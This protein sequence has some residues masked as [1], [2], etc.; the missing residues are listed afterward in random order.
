ML[1]SSLSIIVITA[2]RP[3]VLR[4]CL[5]ALAGECTADDE[6]IVVSAS[7]G[8]PEQAF[9]TA[10][11]RVRVLTS[12]VRNMPHQRN[13]GLADA[14][15]EWVAFVDDDAVVQPGWRAAILHGFG[16]S[17]SLSSVPPCLCGES[18][19][20][21]GPGMRFLPPAGAA[22]AHGGTEERESVGS[23]V[24]REI[25]KGYEHIRWTTP[26]VAG[27]GGRIRGLTHYVPESAQDV[28]CGQG[29]NMAF[30]RDALE[31]IGGFDPAY[32]Q[33]ANCEETDVFVRLRRAGWRVVYEPAAAVV[34]TPAAPVD[35]ERSEFDRR[36]AYWLHRNRA[37]FFGKHFCGRTPFWLYLVRDTG[38]TAWIGVRRVLHL[39][40]QTACVVALAVAGNVAGA[41]SGARA[42][43]RARRGRGDAR[44]DASG[45]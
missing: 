24:G 15:G 19:P 39:A 31:Q 1:N 43:W 17:P 20:H 45:G 41:C 26:P 22:G 5:D 2:E 9:A 4:T 33:R 27:G 25:L 32:R 14:R 36:S 16:T 18:P 40:A 34:H 7:A 35:Y 44:G 8:T 11:G 23:V 12:P 10:D 29:C 38:F 28:E 42:A 3:D 21:P 6:V 13:L 37:Y 30:R